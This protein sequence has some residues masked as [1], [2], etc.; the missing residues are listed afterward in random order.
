[1]NILFQLS[2]NNIDQ[3][4]MD[5]TYKVL[6]PNIYRFKLIVICGIDLIKNKT[7]L[8][9][10]ILLRNE[11]E[12]TFNNIFGYL[13]AKYSFKSRRFMYD[14]NIAQIKSIKS[15]FPDCFIHTCFFHFSQ[16]IWQNFKK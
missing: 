12:D 4:F 13:A 2:N 15:E 9:S 8:C 1:M 5:Y 11:N 3:F 16:A 14:F 7:V 6:P 10:L